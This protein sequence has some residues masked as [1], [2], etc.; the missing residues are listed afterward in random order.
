MKRFLKL[1][2][3]GIDLRMHASLLAEEI[4][5]ATFDAILKTGVIEKD[6][7]ADWYP[8][9]GPEGDNCPMRVFPNPGHPTHAYIAVCGNRPP[10]CKNI[11]LNEVDLLQVRFSFSGIYKMLRNQLRINGDFKPDNEVFPGINYLGET[12]W[13][14][15]REVFLATNAASRI[16]PAFLTTRRQIRAANCLVLAPSKQWISKALIDQYGPGSAI[17][18]AFLED[19]LIVN[20]GEIIIVP[21]PDSA[22]RVREPEISYRSTAEPKCRIIDHDGERTVTESEYRRLQDRK[23]EFDLFIDTISTVQTGRCRAIRKNLDGSLDESSLT[24]KEASLLRQ[25]ITKKKP[26][27]ARQLNSVDLL[28]PDKAVETARKKVD[29]NLSRREWRAFQ[30]LGSDTKEA[31]LFVFNPPPGFK[32]VVFLPLDPQ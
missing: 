15:R 25:L 5:V 8:C 21:P 28:H 22:D 12:N 30:T 3:G 16:F 4:G 32:F 10:R 29:V 23:G 2:K 19:V 31:K 14:G 9:M 24:W 26:L 18:L 1:L 20:K 13:G 11:Y 17:E 27:S 6:D 7:L